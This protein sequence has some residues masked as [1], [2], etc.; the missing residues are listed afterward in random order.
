MD[1]LMVDVGDG[2]EVAEND[3]VILIGV[4]GEEQISCWDLAETQGTIPY[5]IMCAV[6]ARVPRVTLNGTRR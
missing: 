6:S 2:H 1:H 5:E 4:D 3:A